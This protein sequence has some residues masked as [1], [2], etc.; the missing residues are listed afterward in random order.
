LKKRDIRDY[1]HDILESVDDVESF[2]EGM[3]FEEFIKDR[4]TKNAVMRSIEVIG[5]ASRQLPVALREKYS[6]VPWKEIIGM[7]DKLIHGYSGID[8][9]TVWKAAK[10]DVP[11]LKKLIQKILRDLE[12]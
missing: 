2:V 11:S 1:L 7:R 5:E 9:E 6:E 3:S 12:K 4:K 8:Y 10:E